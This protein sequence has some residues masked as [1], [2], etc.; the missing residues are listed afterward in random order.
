MKAIRSMNRNY[1]RKNKIKEQNPYRCDGCKQNG[2]C[3]KYF[4]N[5]D[6]KIGGISNLEFRCV[7]T[8]FSWILLAYNINNGT[9]IFT[10][11]IMFAIPLFIDY[12]KFIPN[13]K[14]REIIKKMEMYLLL[15]WILIGLVGQ[16]GI[17]TIAKE[18]N[19]HYLHI[20]QDFILLPD[21]NF[22]YKYLA[23]LIGISFAMTFLDIFLSKSKGEDIMK[24]QITKS[25]S[26]L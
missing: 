20:S 2:I 19:T 14:I 15:V 11:L 13:T 21:Y 8:F 1:K 4:M 23:W 7:Y 24:A 25:I 5:I 18:G 22:K 12:I 10:S 16:M 26:S 9:S 6:E 3:L 17:L